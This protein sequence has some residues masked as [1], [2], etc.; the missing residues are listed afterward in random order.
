MAAKLISFVLLPLYSLNFSVAEYGIISRIETFWQ[1][2]FALFLFG[3]ESGIVRWY[4]KIDDSEQKKKFLFSVTLFL[5]I[6]NLLFTV[7]FFFGTDFFSDLIFKSDKY[8]SLIFYASLIASMEAFAFIFFLLLRINEKAALYTFL[9]ILAAVLNLSI[10]LYYILYTDNKLDGVFIARVI[11]PLVIIIILIPYYSGFLK[12]GLDLKNLKGLILYSIPVMFATLA[13]TLLNQ[14]DRFILGYLGNS[15]QVGLYS[16]AYNICGLLNFMVIAPFGLAFT[17]LSWKKLKDKNALRFFTKN[18]TYLFFTV[19]YLALILSLSIPNLIKI[20]TLNN[21]YWYAKDIVPWISI[22]M[23]FYGISTIGF[24]SFYVSK[25]TY[26]ILYIMLISLVINVSLNIILIPF[27][28]MYGAAVSNFVSFFLLC[29][30]TYRFSM[31]N[32]FFKYEWGKIFS[33]IFAFIILVF[34]FYY[35]NLNEFTFLNIILKTVSV[36]LFPVILYLLN[37]FEPVEIEGIKGLINKYIFHKNRLK[38]EE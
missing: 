19:T 32:Y 20:F 36:I 8:S 9:S 23:P 28:N 10:Q 29:L 4:T 31:K 16:L 27:F 6:T 35:F 11:S 17:V 33:M 7:I 1:I 38:K 34:P 5:F 2:L 15:T 14:S 37:F 3:L 30:I 22:A 18:I 13:G 26:Y 12:A 21:N 24:F 25:K